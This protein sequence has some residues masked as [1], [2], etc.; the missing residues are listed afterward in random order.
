M[1]ATIDQL[2]AMTFTDLPEMEDISVI[3]EGIGKGSGYE[4]L[5]KYDQLID[6]GLLCWQYHFE[7]LNLCYAAQV[8]FFGTA[9]QIFPD[10]PIST[11]VKMSQD[12]TYPAKRM[13]NLSGLRGSIEV[14]IDEM[15]AKPT[16]AQLM[17]ELEK[18]PVGKEWL[19]ELESRGTLSS[20]CHRNGWCHPHQLER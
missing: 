10:V 19:K 7:F 5:R 9:N 20:T 17:K 1:T 16:A 13:R 18:H 4:L 15:F 3:K 8:T 14:G 6:L 12:S 2:E 11:L